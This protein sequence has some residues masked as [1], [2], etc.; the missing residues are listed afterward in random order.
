MSHQPLHRALADRRLK[1]VFFGETKLFVARQDVLSFAGVEVQVDPDAI[2]T[3]IVY[4]RVTKPGMD[5]PAMVAQLG[6][7]GVRVLPTAPDQMRAVL[8]YHVSAADVERALGVFGRV[9]K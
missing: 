9:M 6:E 4:F 2:A 1:S 3:N 8:N 7:L 5:A